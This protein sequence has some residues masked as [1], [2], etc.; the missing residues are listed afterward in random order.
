ME[1]SARGC[2]AHG[3]IQEPTPGLRCGRDR[4]AAAAFYG[5]QFG[6][7]FPVFVHYGVALWVPEIGGAIDPGSDAHDLVMSLYG[8]MS[9]GERN[10]IKVRVKSAMSAQAAAEGRF[11]GGRPPYGYVLGDAGLHPNPGKAAHGQRLRRL[12]LDPIA[13][14]VVAR[15]F[16]EWITGAGLQRIAVGLNADAIPSPSGHDPS[17]NLHRASGRGLWSKSAVRAIVSNPRY[18]GRQVWNRQRRDEVLIDVED[19]ALGHETRM[20][21]NDRKDWIWSEDQTHEPIVSV[22]E[23][24]AAKRRFGTGKRS[25]GGRHAAPGRCYVLRGHPP[26]RA[27]QSADGRQLEPRSAALPLPLH[28]RLSGARRRAPTECLR[29]RGRDP[30]RPRPVARDACSIPRTST[31]PARRWPPRAGLTRRRLLRRWSSG[32]GSPSATASSA[33]T[34]RPSPATPTQ[35]SSPGG[36][37]RRSGSGRTW[38][39]SSPTSAPSGEITRNEARAL[40]EAVDD[41]TRAIADASPADKATLYRELGIE[42]TYH[43][44][45]R[46]LVEAR[47]AWANER[48]GGGT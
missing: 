12:D 29:P 10:R 47:P 20:R 36:S 45:G 9:K 8:G 7:T 33:G 4:R 28:R 13:S 24:E 19:V 42:L 14:L 35:P 32:G 6:L 43:P 38:S 11:L 15:I 16:R 22:D 39:T 41:V 30:P 44:D 26:V 5:N 46:V 31:P 48:V 21:W 17:R 40:V 1:A 34:G 37:P 3:G 25:G 23:F 18:T 2:V 27:V